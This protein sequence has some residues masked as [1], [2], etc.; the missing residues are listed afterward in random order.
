MQIRFLTIKETGVFL[1]GFPLKLTPTEKRF[2]IKIAEDEAIS[3]D[4]LLALLP[5]HVSRGNI[6]VH[7]NSINKKAYAISGRKLVV[8]QNRHYKINPYM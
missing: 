5:H 8:Y 6:T 2:L 4:G 7:I 3:A 1:L